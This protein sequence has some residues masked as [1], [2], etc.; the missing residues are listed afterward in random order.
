MLAGMLLLLFVICNDLS[1]GHQGV[2]K[3]A[4]RRVC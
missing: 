4:R 2:Q 1:V 3:S